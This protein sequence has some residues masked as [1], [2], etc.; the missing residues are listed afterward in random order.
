MDN[1]F[2]VMPAYNEAA[3]ISQVIGKWYPLLQLGSPDSRL[4][5]VN[6]GS[7]DDTLAICREMTHRLDRLT[8][9]D[10]ANSG[11]G[12]ACLTAY[13]Y[14]VGQGA[15]YIFQ[16]DS[17][18]QTNPDE[19]RRFWTNRTLYDIQIGVRRHR[20]DGAARILVTKVLQLVLL[21]TIGVSVRD[22]NTPFR[23]ISRAAL[24]RYLNLIPPDFFLANALMTAI[25][26]YRM[27]RVGWHDITFKPRAAGKNSINMRRI[28][29]IGLH[30]IGAFRA[31][32]KK[33][34]QAVRTADSGS[35]DKY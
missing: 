7:R 18:D 3:A 20:Q 34:R 12:P 19:V 24:V 28:W 8:V 16:T 23:L 30:S 17:D 5:I 31:A 14:A 2:I 35:P 13:R 29:T 27:D 1:L 6:D 32:G 4:V 33:L 22:A 25:A 26:V 10:K 21:L 15:D 9:L 11:H